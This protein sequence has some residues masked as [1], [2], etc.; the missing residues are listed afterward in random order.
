MIAFDSTVISHLRELFK[1]CLPEQKDEIMV[2][3]SKFKGMDSLKYICTI[4]NSKGKLRKKELKNILEKV[5]K[6]ST[7][8]S[9]IKL[10]QFNVFEISSEV[11]YLKT[12]NSFL[13]DG[14]QP[15]E[16]TPKK[17][18]VDFSSPNV[19]TKLHVGH[20][21]STI[22]GESICRLLEFFGHNVLRLNHGGDWDSQFGML[23][24][25]LEDEFPMFAQVPP[26]I[27]DLEAFY[28]RSKARFDSDEA[29]KNAPTKA[30]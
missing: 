1:T 10:N 16:H 21:R 28:K 14:V 7:I 8:F 6:S 13:L 20:M 27:S 18:V 17:V 15:P 29:L 26:Q 12:L 9:V 22:I 30:L 3:V 19:G 24:A 23:I 11:D 4:Q 2:V 25:H 5:L